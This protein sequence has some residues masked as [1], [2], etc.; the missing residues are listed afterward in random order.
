MPSRRS[1]W[2]EGSRT[3]TGRPGLL[4]GASAYIGRSG[5][6]LVDAEGQDLDVMTTIFE[7]HLEWKQSGFNL[8]ALAVQA[9]LDDTTRLNEVLSL[10]AEPVAERLRGGYVELG[11]DLFATRPRGALSLTPFVR[12]EGYN[13]QSRL[14]DGQQGDPANDRTNWTFGVALKPIDQVVIKADYV[15]RSNQADTGIDQFNVALGY[16][17]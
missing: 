5:Q 2:A 6:D 12:W 9:D 14:A 1:R 16:I 10:E 4:A 11:Y 7:G 8:R 13:T 15:N 17:F 3:F